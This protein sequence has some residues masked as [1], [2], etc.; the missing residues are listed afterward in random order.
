[1]DLFSPGSFAA[2]L[3][4]IA[5][6]LVLAGDNAVV[7]GM[8]AMGLPQRLRAK[9]IVIGILA[10]TVLR[11]GFALIAT[12]LLAFTGLLLAGGLRLMWVS[13]KMG[14]ELRHDEHADD[15]PHALHTAEVLVHSSARKTLGQ[16]VGQ[17]VIADVSMSI[18][19]VLAV[20]GAAQRHMEALVFG[21][22]LSVL[23]MGVASSLIA[24]VLGR[25]RWIA[26]VGL[27]VILYVAVRM[28]YDGSDQLL[29]HVL[30]PIPLI[31]GPMP[32]PMPWPALG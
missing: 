31:K 15:A 21:L 8:A 24:R 28:I 9:A 32:M 27:A 1:L 6:D 22:A 17:I 25:F 12:Q 14:Q 11:I 4:V 20:A 13:Y 23:L 19:N 29:G 10:A 30:P 5:I 2:F 7:I 3:Q 16:A 18:D 26:W